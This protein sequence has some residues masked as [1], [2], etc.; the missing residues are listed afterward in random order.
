MTVPG[1]ARSVELARH[2]PPGRGRRRV[3][4]SGNEL[5]IAWRH[6][7][8][9]T[10][11]SP[12]DNGVMAQSEPRIRCM[13][14]PRVSRLR[15][16]RLLAVVSVLAVPGIAQADA[17]LTWNTTLLDAMRQT[18]HCWWTGRRKWRGNGDVDTAMFDAVNAATGLTYQPYAY[19]GTAMSGASADA[20]ARLPAI[21]R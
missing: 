11:H 2:D 21:R 17:I 9:F 16:P 4:Q 7:M 6:G 12:R 15:A 13:W 10:L 8:H 5:Q 19:R 18:P 14:R 3:P 20:A 1:A